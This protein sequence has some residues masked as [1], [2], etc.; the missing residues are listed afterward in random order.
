M[1]RQLMINGIILAALGTGLIA[2]TFFA[3]S[4]FIMAAL[5]RLPAPQ[6]IA[7]MQSINITVITPLFMGV[8][9][10]TAL[11]CVGLV[12]TALPRWTDPGAVWVIAG[13]LLYVLG[14][15][16]VTI[17]FNVPRNDVLAA[18]DPASSEAA[19]LWARY[20][21]VWTLWNHVRGLASLAACAAFV[22]A[23]RAAA[24]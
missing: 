1:T 13:G 4:T 15:I 14:A 3:F 12:A 2:G 21:T 9:F 24:A 23:L 11:L 17:L 5:G 10:G 22:L 7:A 18:L 6:G 19:V 20:V 8:L 16:L